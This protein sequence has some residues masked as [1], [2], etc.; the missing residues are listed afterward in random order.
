M[1]SVFVSGLLILS[2]AIATGVDKGQKQW[3]AL[4]TVPP[5]DKGQQQWR[6]VRLP[7]NRVEGDQELIQSR[8]LQQSQQCTNDCN[9]ASD[10]DC[11][12]GGPGA[13]YSSC[14]YGKDCD[15]CG[16]R[17]ALPGQVPSPPPA[18][19]ICQDP[20]FADQWHHGVARVPDAWWFRRGSG[21]TRPDLSN[22]TVIV[23]DDGVDELHPDLDVDDYIGWDDNGDPVPQSTLASVDRQHGT[24]CAGIVAAIADNN[25]G[26]CGAAPGAR[27]SSA[28]LLNGLASQV[29]D[30]AEADSLDYFPDADVHTNSWGP[31]DNLYP[32]TMGPFY[33]EALDRARTQGRN[34]KGKIVVF[35]AG[36]GGR[37]DNSNHDP[38]TAHRFTIS[39][40]AV[41]DGDV[42]TWYSEPGSCILISAPSNGGS[43]GITTTDIIG[44]DGYTD[45]NSTSSFGGT[46][47]ATPLVSGIIALILQARPE[48]TWRDV[49]GVVALSA[50]KNDPDDVAW[51]TNAAG[52]WVH[53]FYG[54]GVIDAYA[55]VQLATTWPLLGPEVSILDQ[56]FVSARTNVTTA[57][58]DDGT[59]WIGHVYIDTPLRLETVEVFIDVT[60]EWKGDLMITLISP[61]GTRSTFN[62]LF[63]A[64]VV[65]SGTSCSNYVSSPC[66]YAP[67]IARR[68]SSVRYRDEVSM[69]RWT[70]E[71]RDVSPTRTGTVGTPTLSLHGTQTGDVS[72]TTRSAFC[73]EYKD[74]F[75][76]LQCCT[77]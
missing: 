41:T 10:G 70:F 74:S 30:R 61:G 50:R 25:I 65:T 20:L 36:N 12:D 3:R 63:A 67:F 46:S 21:L 33:A 24:A 57:I 9:Y 52:H 26:G 64:K 8:Q 43:S 39:V 73:K 27:L 44:S 28:A 42:M 6:T 31:F 11:D 56:P 71:I 45:T 51:S 76:G 48:L 68:M 16:P 58:P 5:L 60:H 62:S 75:K 22:I 19:S 34:G 2:V 38:Y 17:D 13:E 23:V 77:T 55:A 29:F 54:F 32:S 35:A 14:R 53:P 18:P 49:H 47:A 40:G 72:P 69:G 66:T 7:E 37:N 4:R 15:D 1:K 59:P